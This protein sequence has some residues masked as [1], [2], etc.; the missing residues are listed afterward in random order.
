MARAETWNTPGNLVH[1]GN[2]QQQTLRCGE[3]RT[4]RTGLERT[5]ERTRS[6]RFGLHL[7]D[8]HGLSEDILSSPC[9]PF[10]H[11]LGHGG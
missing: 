5:V 4:E 6:T 10:V 1:I 2:H 3:G 7:H 8:L 11:I 9:G